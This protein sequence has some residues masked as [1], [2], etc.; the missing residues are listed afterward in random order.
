MNVPARPP[1]MKRIPGLYG[2]LL[3]I[4]IVYQFIIR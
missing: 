2:R 3:L 4:F 1:L